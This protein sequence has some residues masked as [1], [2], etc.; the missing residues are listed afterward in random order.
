MEKITSDMKGEAGDGGP[1]GEQHTS[2]G[3]NFA[4]GQTNST[5]RSLR[6][7]TT[8]PKKSATAASVSES[9]SIK[10]IMTSLT[11]AAHT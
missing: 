2:Q 3:S 11:G 1:G 10:A 8:F 4:R 7:L 9:P 6:S 5:Y